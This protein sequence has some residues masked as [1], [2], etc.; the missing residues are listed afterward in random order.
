MAEAIGNLINEARAAAGAG[1]WRAAERLWIAVRARE[2][3][4]PMAL[5]ALAVHAL[6]RGDAAGAAPLAEAACAAA[7]RDVLAHLTLAKAR[8]ALGDTA[9]ED[10]AIHAA[11]AIDPY[12]LAALL[13]KGAFL[14]RGGKDKAAAMCFRAALKSAP[15]EARWPDALRDQLAHAKTAAQIYGA[16][17][18]ARLVRETEDLRAQMTAAEAA[19]WRE[20]LAIMAGL[21]RPFHAEAN[22]L[23]IPRLP[24]LPF[25][26]RE[27]FGWIPGL[28]A[29]AGAIRAELEAALRAESDA[30]TPYITLKPGAPVDQWRALN[31]SQDWSAYHLWRHGAPMTDNLARCPETAGALEQVELAVI[32]AHSPNVMFSALAPRTRIPPHHGET[33][34]RVVAHLPLIAPPGCVFRVGAEERRWREGEILVFDDTIEHEARNDGEALRVVLIFDLWNPLLSPVE[35][36][37]AEAALTA[38]RLA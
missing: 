17:F 10:A 23:H 30:F 33:N 34:A 38:A 3:D 25:F 29:R 14:E 21:A 24:A 28:E 16:A 13:A 20:T 2:P 37:M 18:H 32:A 7:P 6:Q 27:M 11:L 12:N 31:H 19:R 1:D 15:P 5:F 9:G 36:R 8:G 4:H 35:R 26:E 22:Q